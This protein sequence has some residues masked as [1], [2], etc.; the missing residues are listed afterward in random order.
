M[1]LKNK[2]INL[3]IPQSCKQVYNTQN[4]LLLENINNGLSKDNTKKLIIQFNKTI[5]DMKADD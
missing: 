2:K 4:K 1:K 3:K 5:L